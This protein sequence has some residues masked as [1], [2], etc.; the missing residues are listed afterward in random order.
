MSIFKEN[1]RHYS[2]GVKCF[3]IILENHIISSSA[4][5][6]AASDPL[7]S[8]KERC[9]SLCSFRSEGFT[10][11]KVTLSG[12]YRIFSI[13]QFSIKPPNILYH[14]QTKTALCWTEFASFL[15]GCASR[16]EANSVQQRAVF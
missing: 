3:L 5:T 9:S 12:A 14:F 1:P 8:S 7:Y 6:I 13:L 4:R 15:D 16:K 10:R 2:G 11:K